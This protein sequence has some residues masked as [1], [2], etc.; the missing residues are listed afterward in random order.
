MES[1]F[2]FAVFASTALGQGIFINSPAAGSK[3]KVGETITGFIQAM[4][5]IGIAI[6]IQSC[7]ATR[8]CPAPNE[9]LQNVLYSGPFAP[10]YHTGFY[11]QYQN[12]T[13]TVPDVTGPAQIGITRAFLVGAGWATTVGSI[14]SNYT[15]VA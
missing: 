15:I 2:A 11:D 6:G 7:P 12:F 14:A 10:E 5:E 4:A 8:P 3:L 9:Y 1:I 13:L